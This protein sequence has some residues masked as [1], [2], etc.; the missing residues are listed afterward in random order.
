MYFSRCPFRNLFIDTTTLFQGIYLQCVKK[1]WPSIIEHHVYVLNGYTIQIKF[2]I[3]Q[4]Y[5][6]FLITRVLWSTIYMW[7]TIL[8]KEGETHGISERPT[9]KETGSFLSFLHQNGKVLGRC[10]N[11]QANGFMVLLP[12]HFILL[13]NMFY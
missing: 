13:S 1:P 4:K 7:A 2:C 9:E 10:T 8:R 6:L 3:L 12:F 5:V 11:R